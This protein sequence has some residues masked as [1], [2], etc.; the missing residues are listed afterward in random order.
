M[1]KSFTI[2]RE[3]FDLISVLSD[4]EQGELLLALVK[5]GLN[6]EPPDNLNPRQMA[7][8]VNLKRPIEKYIKRSKAANTRWHTNDNA[9]GYANDNANEYANDNANEYANEYANDNANEYANDNANKYANDN[10][11]GY[12]NEYAQQVVNVNVNNNINNNKNNNKNINNKLNSNIN[13]LDNNLNNIDINNIVSF[14]ENNF[15]RTISSYEYEQIELLIEKYHPDITLYAFKKTLEAGKQSL[16]YTKGILKNWKQ[17]NL[18]TLKEIIN[19]EDKFE[20][21]NNKGK[22]VVPVPDWVNEEI[23]KSG[24][25]IDD[26]EFKDFINNFRK[27]GE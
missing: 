11:N 3:Y 19:F 25:K 7:V 9:N 20:K 23:K 14:I 5:F 13:N 6:E 17:D 22:R 4:K 18:E 12:A 8:F 1:I 26:K 10:A 15:N 27:E 21:K 2:Y 24:E 16:N